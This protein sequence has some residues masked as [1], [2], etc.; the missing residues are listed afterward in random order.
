MFMS[1]FLGLFAGPLYDSFG[2][3]WL[4]LTGS[5]FIFVGIFTTG[6]CTKAYQFILSYGICMGIG[7]GLMMF[8]AISIVSCWFSKQKRSLFMGVVQ[9]GGSAGGVVFP[10]LLRFLFPK[11]GFK[12]SMRIVAFFNLG[13][14]LLGAFLAKDRLKEIRLRTG[15]VD[16][17]TMWNKLTH[18]VDLTA[19]KEKQLLSLSVSLFMNE[20][21]LMNVL[22]YFSSYAMIH[23]VSQ[24]ESFNMLTILNALGILGA[25]V[26]SYFAGK[27]GSFNVMILMSSTLTLI[28]FVVW[29]PFGKYKPA[30]Y[31]FVAVFGFCCSSTFA[32]TGAT[33][34]TITPK[35]SDF[36][37]RYGAAY[38]FV[39]LGNLISLPISGSF[40]K[41]KNA[42]YYNHMVIFIACICACSSVL[43]VVSRWTV[44]G[45]KF[46]VCV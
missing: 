21:A 27:Y 6:E 14:D 7:T 11:Y 5:L 12:W 3:R 28:M 10:I 19:Y 43:F 33:V 30:M 23:G 31:V 41:V 37:K 17:R 45:R 44:V 22:T 24:G 8:P 34:S 42:K 18:T 20:F 35:T 46:R 29:L 9:S 39:S 40:I 25:Y 15:E 26:P 16:K 1:M 13:V 32:L 36:G 4:L 38:A 2:S